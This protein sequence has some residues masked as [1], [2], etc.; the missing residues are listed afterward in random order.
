MHGAKPC[1]VS[2]FGRETALVATRVDISDGF[3]HACAIQQASYDRCLGY[4]LY[5]MATLRPRI[6]CLSSQMNLVQER[7]GLQTPICASNERIH[8]FQYIRYILSEDKTVS[9]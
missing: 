7:C 9:E 6:H 2:I 8:I 3:R 5:H 4:A 1:H